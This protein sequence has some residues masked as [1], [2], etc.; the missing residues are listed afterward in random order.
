M[1]VAEDRLLYLAMSVGLDDIVTSSLV[2]PV[3]CP[4]VVGVG[5]GGCDT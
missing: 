2:V 3:S 1:S 4:S 5:D